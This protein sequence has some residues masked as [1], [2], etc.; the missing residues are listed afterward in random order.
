MSPTRAKLP[1]RRRSDWPS[2]LDAY[3]EQR[4]RMP[5]AWG[6]QDCCQFAREGV[7]AIT[8]ADPAKGW[9]LRRYTT[10]R[11][12]A[13]TLKRIGGVSA[14]PAR[15]GLEPVRVALARRGDVVEREGTLGICIGAHVA[16]AGEG[17]LIFTPVLDCTSAW[18]VG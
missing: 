6:M 8:G 10:A 4:R 2:R 14:L 9:G 16:F 11:G 13:S 1:L 3:I 17:G 18:R 15:A 5:F 7:R 12:A